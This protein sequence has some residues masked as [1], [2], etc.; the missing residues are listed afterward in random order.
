MAVSGSLMSDLTL[1][2]Y[3]PAASAALAR[4]FRAG[5]R[6]VTVGRQNFTSPVTLKSIAERYDRPTRVAGEGWNMAPRL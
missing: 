4:A 5:G 6:V 2:L 1:P 3:R